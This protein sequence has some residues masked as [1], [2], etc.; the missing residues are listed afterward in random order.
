[1]RTKETKRDDVKMN[2]LYAVECGLSNTGG[3]A[4]H[5]LALR[6]S[7]IELF[8]QALA[9]ELQVPDAPKADSGQLPEEAQPLAQTA[10]Q[11]FAST[12]RSKCVV[13]AGDGQP[14][15]LHALVHAINH[16]LQNV[17]ETVRY[18]APLEA[19]PVDHGRQIAELVKDMG[20]RR[21]KM[22]VI[23][24]GNPVYTTPVNLNFAENLKQ[25]PL[26]IH[27][28]LY[29]DETAVLCDWHIPEAHYLESWSDGR[30]YDGTAS[31]IQPL[32]APLYHGRTAHEVLATFS[33]VARTRGNGDCPRALAR[34]VEGTEAFR[35]L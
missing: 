21:V 9:V 7:K 20:D 5:R 14:A 34:L 18:T 31:V 29:Q 8:A 35:Q 23:L 12:S 10:R 4:D 6:A 17:G 15:S 33:G 30:A 1:M 32:I 19:K 28:G 11:G 13:L 2:R 22:L 3:V 24:S 16:K 25:V 26:R 27:L